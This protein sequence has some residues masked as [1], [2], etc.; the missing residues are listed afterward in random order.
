[1]MNLTKKPTLHFFSE[2]TSPLD[3]PTVPPLELVRRCLRHY[4]FSMTLWR[5]SEL[6]LLVRQEMVPPVLDIGCG[7]GT[8]AYLLGIKGEIDGCDVSY[9]AV[10]NA[11]KGQGAY[12][13]LW[14]ANAEALPLKDG[15]FRTVIANCM[16]EHVTSLDDVLSEIFRILEPGGLVYLTV[17]TPELHRNL[18]LAK[19]FSEWNLSFAARKYQGF[20]NKAIQHYHIKDREE[21][22]STMHNHGF[23][24]LNSRPYLPIRT[25][26]LFEILLIFRL[27]TLIRSRFF[28]KQF[29]F[30]RKRLAGV[31]APFLH[32]FV[33]ELPEKGAGL[34]I[35]AQKR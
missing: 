19:V 2:Y 27:F 9:N 29:F 30:S 14:C 23:E 1:M 26:W 17:P 33:N 20:F 6:A 18:M 34:M 31:A 32:T 35:Q 15:T 21:W 11:E 22:V 13:S 12:R 24:V 8:F 10:K 28:T 4:N 25:I 16:L 5:A 7:D 3:G